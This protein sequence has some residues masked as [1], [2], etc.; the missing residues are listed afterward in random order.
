MLTYSTNLIRTKHD[1]QTYLDVLY[2]VLLLF[3]Q[4]VS[5]HTFLFKGSCLYVA[6]ED[7]YALSKSSLLCLLLRQNLSIKHSQ[8]S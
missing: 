5:T 2:L 6:L 1:P 3:A 8:L 7:D 4:E